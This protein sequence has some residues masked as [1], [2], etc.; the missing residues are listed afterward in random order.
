[1]SEAM[2]PR[3]CCAGVETFLFCELLVRILDSQLVSV[4]RGL[5]VSEPET[6]GVLSRLYYVFLHLGIHLS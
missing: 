1:M 6:P 5:E 2:E 3:Y 4:E